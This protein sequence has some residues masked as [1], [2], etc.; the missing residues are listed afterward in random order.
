M[1]KIT[2]SFSA[3]VETKGIDEENRIIPFIVSPEQ[4]DRD[5]DLIKVGGIDL[6]AYEKNPVVHYNHA[7][8]GA[9]DLPIARMARYEKL[10]NPERFR[11]YFQFPTVEEYKFADTIYRL[12]KAKYINANS[13]TFSPDYSQVEH[14]KNMVLDGKQVDRIFH[15]CEILEISLCGVPSNR[16]GLAERMAKSVAAGELKQADID[17]INKS[18]LEGRISML[19][20]QVA[21][22]LLSKTEEVED[23]DEEED[24]FYSDLLAMD[25]GN[26]V[27][28][29]QTDFI[30]DDMVEDLDL[31]DLSDDNN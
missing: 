27:D 16:G 1:S 28:E 17:F 11:M 3:E 19:E 4:V 13:I 26:G 24:T 10:D 2:K 5:G 22:L 20:K 21:E 14:P 25:S 15:K 8:G 7:W 6:S 30:L 23:M 29:D 12:T 9:K 18:N 31:D